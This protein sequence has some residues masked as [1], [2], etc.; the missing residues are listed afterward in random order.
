MEHVTENSI[1][2][3]HVR[4]FHGPRASHLDGERHSN[5]VISDPMQRWHTCRQVC[6][7]IGVMLRDAWEDSTWMR[8]CLSDL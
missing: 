5:E 4:V 6:V 3:A 7:C 1:S 2:R 8:S